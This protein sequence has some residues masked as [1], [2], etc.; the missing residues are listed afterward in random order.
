MIKL[1]SN[2]NIKTEVCGTWMW[3][4]G[5][6]WRYKKELGKNGLGLKWASKKQQWYWSPA[7]F[8][9]KS[10]RVFSMDEIRSKYGSVELE[11]ELRSAIG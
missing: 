2:V 9:K 6:T 7:G 5:E 4:S 1:D 3:I 10:K 8:R 11:P